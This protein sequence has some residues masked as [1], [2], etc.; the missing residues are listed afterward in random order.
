MLNTLIPT[1]QKWVPRNYLKKG[2]WR[3]SFS[4]ERNLLTLEKNG[5]VT[6]TVEFMTNQMDVESFQGPPKH[7]MVYDEEPREDVRKE[8]LLRMVTAER[9]RELY[10]MTPTK[11]LCFDD[12]TEILTENGW[13]KYNEV[14]LG[15]RAITFNL[16][17]QKL[18]WDNILGLYYN[19]N[20]DGILHHL[21]NKN[22]D[23]MVTP[24]HRWAVR[25]ISTGQTKIAL[26]KDLNSNHSI[27]RVADF[28]GTP[29]EP[30][31]PNAFVEL[32]G[33]IIGDGTFQK[34]KRYVNIYQSNTRYP[35]KCERIRE[36]LTELGCDWKERQYEYGKG[37]ASHFYI[38]GDWAHLWR[39]VLPG[40][41]ISP[42]FLS[43]LTRYQLDIFYRGLMES[44]GTTKDGKYEFWGQRKWDN[45]N[46]FQML[47]VMRGRLANAFQQKDKV[48]VNVSCVNGNTSVNYLKNEIVNYCGIIW[49]AQTRN[50][51]LIARR[52]GT[53]YVTGNTWVKDKILDSFEEN[54]N[55][56]E[57]FKLASVT[58]RFANV[59]V[60]EEI[61]KAL[62]TYDEVKMRLLGEFVSI[63]GLVYGKLF[64]RKVH[65]IEP[66]P[67]D[68]NNHIVYRGLDPHLVKPS[69]CVEVAVDREEN[70]YVVG[71]YAK[72]CDTSEI[73]KDLAERA[74]ER[75]YRLGWAMCDKSAN[76]TIKVL[77]DRNIYQ[78]LSRGENAVPALFTSDKYTGSINAG[79]DEIKQR[80]RLNEK[81]GKPTLFIFNM[82]ENKPLIQAF[83]TMERDRATNEDKSG[84]RD[85]IAEGKWDHHA[86]LRY[87]HQRTVRWMPQQE[88]VPEQDGERYI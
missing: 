16:E 17:T 57:C 46:G 48:H 24:E 19:P 62:D 73:K 83:E 52:N 70:E 86:A 4:S 33:W 32:A 43:E 51:T 44:D 25:Q 74:K 75:K 80:L 35:Q 59:E 13:R 72:D 39:D 12:K 78:E 29:E 49:C 69:V 65:V 1:Y 28:I 71:C 20:Y 6:G 30:K 42:K 56:I 54:G 88:D 82:P 31:Y 81:T 67:L 8:N 38:T 79:V 27:Y 45:I 63:S 68:Y 53:V 10:C 18:E 84:V 37:I 61:L 40:K 2:K 5:K 60:L 7:A 22:F 36:L 47:N 9:I 58:N 64:N 66:F 26:T 55:S 76:S 3:E 34:G 15:E 14:V 50:T 77:G 41:I 85:K 21:T 11:G 23:A 87:I